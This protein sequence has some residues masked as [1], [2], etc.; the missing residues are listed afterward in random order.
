[1]YLSR[2]QMLASTISA[3]GLASAG[4]AAASEGG[5]A[6]SLV[7]AFARTQAFHGVI[8]VWVAGRPVISRAY[9]R[10]DFRDQAPASQS[11]TYA[12]GSISKWFTAALVLR[13]VELGKLRLDTPLSV[14]LPEFPVS[15][16]ANVTL[17]HLLSNTSGLPDLLMPAAKADAGL[18]TSTATAAEI[19]SRFAPANASFAPGSGFDYAFMNWVIVRAVV[20]GQTGA[21]FEALAQT[22]LF[23][24]AGLQ[25]TGIA[26]RGFEGVPGLV[27]AFDGASA[28]AAL[29][30]TTCFGYGAASGTFYSTASDLLTFADQ[31]LSGGLLS[32]HS[33]QDLLAVRH[34]DQSYALG[35]RVRTGDLGSIAWE[36]GS[37]GGY[38]SLLA[39][40]LAD[41]RAVAVLNN[42]DMS[43]D[44]IN[45][46]AT[47]I[48]ALSTL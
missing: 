45:D 10:S 33:R 2:R 46:L 34:A 4:Q 47:S 26:T 5:A 16:G 12:I 44:M 37:V 28:E 20:E 8:A 22:L 40:R 39:Y 21:T 9:G 41:R 6:T 30:M 1:M 18:R 19:V 29:D 42:T 3:L 43:Q 32:R 23:G 36:T 14:L 25:G 48:F 38:K 17:A 7:D 35:G 15:S 13:L 24:P 27:P 31:V 11:S